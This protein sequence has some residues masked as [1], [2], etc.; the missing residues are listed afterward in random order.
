MLNLLSGKK[1]FFGDSI[2]DSDYSLRQLVGYAAGLGTK[3]LEEFDDGS[4]DYIVTESKE[5][6]Y[7]IIRDYLEKNILITAK[8]IAEKEGI[9]PIAET[10]EE[11]EKRKRKLIENRLERVNYLSLNDFLEIVRSTPIGQRH[12]KAE[13]VNSSFL[14]FNI[15]TKAA[16]HDSLCE[17]A[18]CEVVNGKI[19]NQLHCDVTPPYDG[20]DEYSL[21]KVWE[22][23]DEYFNRHEYILAFNLSVHKSN[24]EKSL[25]HFGIELP[26]KKYICAMLWYKGVSNIEDFTYEAI[27]EALNIDTHQTSH[28]CLNKAIS[29]AEITL[30]LLSKRENLYLRYCTLLSYK[31]TFRAPLESADLEGLEFTEYASLHD[32]FWNDKTVVITGESEKYTRAELAEIVKDKGAK[33]TSSISSKTN[34]IVLGHDPGPSKVKKIKELIAGGKEIVIIPEQDILSQND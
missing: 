19:V 13:L 7:D 15:R 12:M 27:T 23:L 29:A 34:V 21:D 30:N 6:D 1:V 10:P 11:K 32:G 8:K 20:Y 25:A 18:I 9:E 16:T 26:K 33:V 14:T 5:S 4:L 3:N 17:V 2:A 31:R 28:K 24:L 22:H